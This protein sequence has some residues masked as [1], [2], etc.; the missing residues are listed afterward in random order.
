MTDDKNSNDVSRRDFTALGVA[1]G[2]TAGIGGAYAAEDVVMKD[3]TIKTPDGVCDAAFIHPAGGSHPGVIIWTDIFG[4]R[5]HFRE[6]G[7]RLAALGYSVLV[8]NPFY[9]TDKSPVIADASKF[10]FTKPEDQALMKRWTT[11][12]NEAGAIERDSA[13]YVAWLDAQKEV[14]KAKKMGTQGYCMGGPLVFRTAATNPSRIGAIATFHGGGLVTGKPDSPDLLIPKMKVK[15]Y[16]AIAASDDAKQPE[17]KDKLKADF[18]AAKLP[19]EVVVY[20][21]MAHGW[22]VSDMPKQPD[23]SPIYNQPEAERAFTALTGLY[24]SAIA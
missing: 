17:A 11:P 8:P 1:A 14:S 4:L 23:G 15:A 9:R 10:D 6:L 7:K 18:A 3:V 20:T 21:G 2:L 19:A 5:P 22:T 13:T 24:K 12:I 16:I